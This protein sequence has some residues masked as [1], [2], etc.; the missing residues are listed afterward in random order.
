MI[1]LDHAATTP[2]DPEVLDAM[3]PYLTEAYGNPSSIYGPGRRARAAIDAARDLVAGALG[4]QARELIFTSGGSESDNL[5]VR[6]VA[7]RN[8]DRGR[9][10]VCSTA[11]CS[12]WLHTM[13]DLERQGFEVTY[14]PVDGDAR[15]S[16]D[17]LAAALRDDT[18]L[19]SVM[20]GNNEV[21]TVEPVRELAAITH[22]R[23]QAYFHTDAVQAFGRVPVG[24]DD[25]GVDLLTISAHKIHG[26][27]GA[28]CLYV[29]MGTRIQPL[30]TGGGHERNRRA[31]TENVA[32]IVGLAKAVEVAVR[33][34]DR[35]AAHVTSV[36]DRLVDGV[37][38]AVEGAR[39]TGHPTERLPQSASFL[40]PG[41]E[42]DSLLMVLDREGLYASSG[43]ACTSGSLEPS[44]VLLAMGFSPQEA[45]GSLRLTVGKRTEEA[46]VDAAVE[47]IQTAVAQLRT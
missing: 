11:W 41:V 33:D 27:K 14:L 3:L 5:A 4:C 6:G 31:G 19:V 7:L 35:D 30:I 32:G 28:G 38:G 34:F 8:A 26:P 47:I 45:L 15:V 12:T 9:H 43:S 18:I 13:Q 44:H 22:E 39:L 29:R 42:G 25:L 40:I 37:T 2:L 36:R 46:E 23:S 24:V 1:Y 10:L 20:T 16:P 17:A 21:G